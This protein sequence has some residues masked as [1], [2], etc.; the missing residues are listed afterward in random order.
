VHYPLDVL[1]G[2]VL[3]VAIAL[4]L[5]AAVRLRSSRAQPAG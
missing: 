4:L 3:G 2:A 1:G 5:R